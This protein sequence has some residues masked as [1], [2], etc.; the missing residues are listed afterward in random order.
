MFVSPFLP[1][2]G[3]RLHA[4]LEQAGKSLSHVDEDNDPKH[5]NKESQR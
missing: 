2:S 3:S 1:R 5:R 4:R